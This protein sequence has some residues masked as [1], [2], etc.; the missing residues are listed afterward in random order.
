[1][2]TRTKTTLKA[3]PGVDESMIEGTYYWPDENGTVETTNVGHVA[4]MIQ[5]GYTKT[6]EVSIMPPA[7]VKG[8]IDCEE[9]G[10]AEV[11]QALAERGVSYPEAG[12]RAALV[13]IAES[14]NVARRRG[15]GEVPA[16]KAEIREN[17]PLPRARVE[18]PAAGEGEGAADAE[19]KAEAPDFAT[20]SYEELKGYLASRGAAFPPNSPKKTL[21]EMAEKVHAE[22]TAAKKVA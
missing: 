8:P 4:I 13:E 14:W 5:H 18:R 16:P 9:M 19:K 3:P 1:M 11:A 15:R 21:R 7:T 12:S 17:V 6:G 22:L 10:R 2:N 20:C